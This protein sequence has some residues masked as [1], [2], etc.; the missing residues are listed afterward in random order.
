MGEKRLGY[1]IRQWIPAAFG[2]GGIAL[3][4]TDLF[5]SQHTGGFLYALLTAAFGEIDP[6]HFELIHHLL[7]KTG[8]FAGYGILSFLFFRALR[9]TV[10]SN[11][12]YLWFS[13]VALTALVAA[14]D[15]WHQSFIPSRTGS[16]RDVLLDTTGAVV[17]QLVLLLPLLLPH[18]RSADASSGRPML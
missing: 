5:S 11:Q 8:H 2:V 14:A 1:I 3:E 12:M 9:N 15:E 10:T 16:V 18:R 4:S 17:M 6:N 7:R 13:S